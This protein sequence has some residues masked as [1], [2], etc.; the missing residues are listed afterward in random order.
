MP[1]ANMISPAPADAADLPGVLQFM[2]LL[3]AV[4]HGLERL[5]KR[6]TGDIGV[7][8]PQRLVLRV[9]TRKGRQ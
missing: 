4:V 3:W 1:H 2:Q 5:S 9:E 8:G 7:T 6:M